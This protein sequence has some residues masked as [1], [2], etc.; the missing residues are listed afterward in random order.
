MFHGL[1][2]DQQVAQAMAIE[3]LST[4]WKRRAETMRGHLRRGEP[5]S[6]NLIDS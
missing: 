6:S 2:D 1:A 4:E 3:H 5:R